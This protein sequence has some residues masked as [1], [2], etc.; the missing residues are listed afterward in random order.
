[1]LILFNKP[2]NVLSQFRDRHSKTPRATLSDFISISKVYPAGR[3]D[4]DSEG[5]L[6][7][8]DDGRLQNQIA[9][10]K[11]GKEKGYWVQVEGAITEQA[12]QQLRDGVLLKD[13]KTRTA[14]VRIISQ[15]EI[16]PRTPP[17]RKRVHIPTSWIEIFIREGKNRQL[18]RMTA[19]VGF[20]TL[21]LIRFQ[22]GPWSLRQLRPGEFVVI[23]HPLQTDNP[24]P[25]TKS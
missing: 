8:T 5:L 15:P 6:L 17:I 23:K 12:I 18:R 4:K 3:L 14:R 2:Y 25:I 10:P 16:W 21:R 9:H 22:V 7:L 20:P 24:K 19:H 13:G 1:M 11:N